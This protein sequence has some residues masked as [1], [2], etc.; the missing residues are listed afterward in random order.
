MVAHD[1]YP[2]TQ[3]QR[4]VDLHKFKASLVYIDYARSGKSIVN[5]SI[6]QPNKLATPLPSGKGYYG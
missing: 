5:H 4:Q 1:F 6:G 3:R 2:S